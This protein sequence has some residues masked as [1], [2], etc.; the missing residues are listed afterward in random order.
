MTT[1]NKLIGLVLAWV[2]SVLVVSVAAFA[3]GYWLAPQREEDP[4]AARTYYESLDLATP[5]ETVHEFCAAFRRGDYATVFMVFSP[6]TQWVVWQEINLLRWG[7]LVRGE[8]AEAV[9]QEICI[10]AQGLGS[11]DY[12]GETTYF[13][14]DLMLAA[15]KHS[16]FL[17]DL[18]GR[19]SVTGTRPAKTTQGGD[20]IDVT[21]TVKGIA[22]EVVFRTVQVPS[23]GK[24]RVLQVILPGG[25]EGP[26]PWAVPGIE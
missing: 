23:S 1:R 3:T 4:L 13:F 18:R 22:G 15:E 14:D 19:E 2:A 8:S 26:I 25:D 10:Y 9:V 6:H 11:C 12:D 5:E 17:V 20:A 16:A 7:Q 21:A 24:W